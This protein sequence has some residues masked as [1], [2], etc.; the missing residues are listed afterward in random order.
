MSAVARG[1]VDC[2]DGIYRSRR[3][4]LFRFFY[5]MTGRQALSEDLTH[6][7]FLRMLRYRHTWQP[8]SNFESWMY[9][10]ARNA[11]ADQGRKRRPETPAV[12]GEMERVE[13]ETRSPADVAIHRQDLA[14][15]YRALRQLPED[16]RELIILSRF[17][18]LSYE[19]IARISGC[20]EGTVKG[21]MFRTM[22][23]L[24]RVFEEI[25]KEKA[26]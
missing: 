6:E 7:V 11:F 15:L 3:R 24:S 25:R 9:R 18:G 5:R 22:K 26:S 21:R 2:M 12:E 23:E 1:D 8:G 4:P 19:Q 16:K 14:T 17:Q 10:I 13:S 20:E